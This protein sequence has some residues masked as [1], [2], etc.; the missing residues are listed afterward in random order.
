MKKVLVSI[1]GIFV[2]IFMLLSNSVYAAQNYSDSV[3]CS[4]VFTVVSTA[5]EEM[6]DKETVA[7][8]DD[9]LNFFFDSAK[10]ISGR[11]EDQVY[12]DVLAEANKVLSE[13]GTDFNRAGELIDRYGEFCSSQI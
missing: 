7:S 13:I 9:L 5:A 3:K 12:N 8:A 2:G 1:T 11:S 6:G 4:A 10:A